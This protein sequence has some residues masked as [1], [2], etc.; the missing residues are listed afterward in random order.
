MSAR[1]VLR[2]NPL[3]FHAVAFRIHIITNI[4]IHFI[5]KMYSL[6]YVFCVIFFL[7]RFVPSIA[8]PT[9][10]PDSDPLFFDS[11]QPSIFLPE[12]ND[13]LTT[14]ATLSNPCAAAQDKLGFLPEGETVLISRDDH[15]QCLPPVNIGADALRLFE[16]PLDS[17]ENTLLPLKEETETPNNPSL[18]GMTGSLPSGGVGNYDPKKAEEEGWQ[19]LQGSMFIVAPDDSTCK[20]LTAGRGTYTIELCCNAI[21]VG[22]EFF[23]QQVRGR[24]AQIDAVTRANQDIAVIFNCICTFYFTFFFSEKQILVRESA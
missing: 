17:L 3:Y 16:S 20:A 5:R 24:A 9:D 4:N 6:L 18:D 23:S 21:Y 10:A 19:P 22:Y 12:D 14:D 8:L 13:F 15:P 7:G 2:R 1:S 11:T